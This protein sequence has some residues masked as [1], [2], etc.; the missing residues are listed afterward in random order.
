MTPVVADGSGLMHALRQLT[1]MTTR[2]RRVRCAFQCPEPVSIENPTVANELYRIAQEAMN[3]AV[4]HGLAKR[5][6]V[7]LSETPDEVCL[8]VMDNG[9]GIPADV[10]GSPGMGLRV[11]K[12]RARVIGGELEIQRRS[13]GGTEVICHVEKTSANL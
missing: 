5:I 6:T 13:R 8:A 3:N 9:S 4:R 11:M 10:S 12:Y 1:E 7:R 2:S